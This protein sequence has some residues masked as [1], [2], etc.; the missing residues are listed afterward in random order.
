MGIYN[1]SATFKRY[2]I[3]CNGK[4]P[5]VKKLSEALE[6]FKAAELRIDGT[7]KVESIG[8]VRPLTPVDKDLAETAGHW[9][10]SDCQ[11]S[12]GMLLRVRYERRKVSASLIAMIF[13]Q[14]IAEFFQS[15]GKPMGRIER[16]KLKD[17]I[18]Q[19]LLKRTLPTVQFT[20]LVWKDQ[21]SELWIFSSSATSCDR[22]LQLFNQ[23]FCDKCDLHISSIDPASSWIEE[24]D[25]D[26]RLQLI[27]RTE[28]AVFS[29]QNA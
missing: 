2:R 15:Q 24:D 27:S 14:K 3:Y 21:E 26:L 29:R 7:P 12:G 10:A 20:D 16:K 28:P 23:T 17:S 6:P 11:V 5:S 13:R 4:S 22:I 9:D 8:W 25:S 18:A 1:G 19:D